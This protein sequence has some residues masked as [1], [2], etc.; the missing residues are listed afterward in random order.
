MFPNAVRQSFRRTPLRE[1][2]GGKEDIGIDH[3][4]HEQ[5]LLYAFQKSCDV[6]LALQPR[7]FGG[8]RKS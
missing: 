8:A 1:E 7:F 4:S 3:D 2:D 6:I 5:Y